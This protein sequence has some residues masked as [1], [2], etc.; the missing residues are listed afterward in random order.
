M[1]KKIEIPYGY[2]WEKFHKHFE[3]NHNESILFSGK[4]GIGKTTFL[5]SYFKKRKDIVA[6]K[7]FPVNYVIN[8]NDNIFELIKIDII[9]QLQI[10]GE[11]NLKEDLKVSKIQTGVSLA[12]NKP[13]TIGK[14]LSKALSKLHPVGE[15]ASV[16]FEGVY[17]LITEFSKY[18][19][20]LN[21]ELKFDD[22]IL[23]E[24]SNEKANEIGSYVEYNLIS[25]LITKV[26]KRIKKKK[27]VVLLIDDLDRLDP[28]HIF[29]LLNIFSSH[30]DYESKSHKYG[31]NKVILV[32]D[33][34]NIESIF[35]HKY[36]DNTDFNGYIDKFY[37]E[38]V[39]EFNNIDAIDVYLEKLDLQIPDYVLDIFRYLLRCF[40]SKTSVTTRQLIKN[41]KFDVIKPFEL[42]SVPF[43]L[44]HNQIPQFNS[45]L[46]RLWIS[47][48]DVSIIYLIKYFSIIFGSYNNFKKALIDIEVS[49]NFFNE[50][51]NSSV[52]KSFGL[53]GRIDY[54]I[55]NK[56]E[57]NIFFNSLGDQN[58]QT[59]YRPDFG[60][61]E[62]EL[63]GDRVRYSIKWN[64]GNP[65]NEEHS[66]FKDY[67]L[68]SHSN[69]SKVRINRDDIKGKIL[70][71]LQTVE[72]LAIKEKLS[73]V[74]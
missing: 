40:S 68:I 30:H 41:D 50:D 49:N 13:L 39:F 10:L 71:L 57:L 36:G 47:S 37:S 72:S 1:S 62:E 61:P 51:I 54:Y 22:N 73:I 9:K 12:L 46:E 70:S 69:F 34:Q 2:V 33:L 59:R 44:T 5:S 56:K 3:L 53:I 7:L 43:K 35:H 74:S 15:V 31:F 14:H 28:D 29:R 21:K 32:C 11:I 25:E 6:I 17:E 24:Y 67:D 55:N 52:I 45:G 27:K 4:Y 20:K 8:S 23:L 58:S 65:Y 16:A 18:E 26:I 42:L 60:Y 38:E 66:Y 64:A 48:D 63:Y 19:A